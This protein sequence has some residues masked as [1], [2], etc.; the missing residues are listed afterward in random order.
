MVIVLAKHHLISSL[1][2]IAVMM[3]AELGTCADTLLATVGTGRAALKTSIFHIAFNLVS[4]ALGLLFFSPFVQLTESIGTFFHFPN[5][6]AHQIALA[7]IVF[8]LSGVLLFLGAIPASERL[9]N[10][11]LP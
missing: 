11:L 10:R 2:G 1:G 3:G 4:I 5:A 8:N 9:L 7:H 6:P